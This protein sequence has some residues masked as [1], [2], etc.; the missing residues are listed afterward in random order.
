MLFLAVLM[1]LG[2]FALSAPD[3]GARHVIRRGQYHRDFYR[4]GGAMFGPG[5]FYRAYPRYG[6]QTYPRTLYRTYPRF[7]G[8][9][10]YVVPDYYGYDGYGYSYPD[11][12][13]GP[14]ISL[15]FGF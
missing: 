10:Q 7:Y 9:P 3:A 13:Y 11:Y 2:V 12:C 5:P 1:S 6:Y 15:R 4:P 14:S 8:G